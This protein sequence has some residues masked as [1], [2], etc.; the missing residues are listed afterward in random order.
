MSRGDVGEVVKLL[1]G[2]GDSSSEVRR[3][4]LVSTVNGGVSIGGGAMG[5]LVSIV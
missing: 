2:M 4:I 1:K 3:R 5:L